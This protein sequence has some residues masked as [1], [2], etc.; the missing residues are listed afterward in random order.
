MSLTIMFGI[1]RVGLSIF[2]HG[3]YWRRWTRGSALTLV[4]QAQL[5]VK[6]KMDELGDAAQ[7]MMKNC[8]IHP[9]NKEVPEWLNETMYMQ[10]PFDSWMAFCLKI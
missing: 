4:T 7:H 6:L 8:Q 2:S 1:F 9:Q 3:V 10:I 5:L